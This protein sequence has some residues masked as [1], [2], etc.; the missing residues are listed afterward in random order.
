MYLSVVQILAF[1]FVNAS[2]QRAWGP[3][4]RF[5]VLGFILLNRSV[6]ACFW[7]PRQF[8]LGSTHCLFRYRSEDSRVLFF[9]EEMTNAG[10]C[11]A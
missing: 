4:L 10:R 11:R 7:G 6:A 8:Y 5:R 1:Y 3:A 2:G 9:I